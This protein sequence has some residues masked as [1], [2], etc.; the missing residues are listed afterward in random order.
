MVNDLYIRL[1]DNVFFRD[2]NNKKLYIKKRKNNIVKKFR[3][4]NGQIEFFNEEIEF[5]M[6]PKT[7]KQNLE[8]IK[9]TILVYDETIIFQDIV[10]NLKVIDANLERVEID[11]LQEGDTIATYDGD[12]YVFETLKDK[13]IVENNNGIKNLNA[14]NNEPPEETDKVEKFSNYVLRSSSG[15]I[16]N[17]LLVCV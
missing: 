12:S 6:I 13:M 8:D 5:K 17:D 1:T 9:I 14:S 4:L 15:I 11:M 2:E 10:G 3:I 16:I 7:E